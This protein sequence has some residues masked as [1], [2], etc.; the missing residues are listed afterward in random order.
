MFNY[1]SADLIQV[2]E[3]DGGYAQSEGSGGMAIRDLNGNVFFVPWV[4]ND[5]FGYDFRIVKKIDV[6]H[7]TDLT[8]FDK[9]ASY[10]PGRNWVFLKD[11]GTV[12][13]Y[14]G[15]MPRPVS[16][17]KG[18]DDIIDIYRNHALKSDGTVWYWTGEPNE[19]ATQV[20]GLVKIKSILPDFFSRMFLDDQSRLWY[21]G[22]YI[23]SS[24][25]ELTKQQTPVMIT[26]IGEVKDAVTI[27]D[28]LIV[29]THS[30][31]LFETPITQS[32]MSKAPKFKRLSTNVMNI[33]AAGS[34]II[35]Q[36][37][38]GTLWG[39][40]TNTNAE[41]GAGQNISLSITPVPVGQPISLEVNGEDVLLTSGVIMRNNQSFIPLRTLLVMLNANISYENNSKV[42]IVGSKEGSSPSIR[43]SINFKNGEILLNEKSIGSQTKAFLLGG[44][45][46]IPLRFISEQ[47]GA[48]VSWTKKD[49]KISILYGAVADVE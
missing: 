39:W 40:G 5:I 47:L 9:P 19:S 13:A 34:H 27:R 20:K 10:M 29:L 46:Y 21:G 48:D 14:S 33:K 17:V 11:N 30:G 45:S 7:I 36:K 26:S 3:L 12:W 38:D 15:F 32:K 4:D 28:S 49:N 25:E 8:N 35:M 1:N 42:L 18:L 24:N 16:A 2:K 44:T 43:V 22:S 6:D 31:D 37:D 23:N 41:L